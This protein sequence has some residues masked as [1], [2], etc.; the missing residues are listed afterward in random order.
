MILRL[1]LLLL[2]CL[3]LA[4]CGRSSEDT[5]RDFFE[6][7]GDNEIEKAAAMFSPELKAR[8]SQAELVRATG[9]LADHMR[10]HRGLKKITLRG[11]VITYQEL[12]LYD[13]ILSFG[14]GTNRKLQITVL[15]RGGEWRVNTAL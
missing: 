14:D 13:A 1:G 6:Q 2:L 3:P 5:V 10:I 12:A 8:F 7:I 4:A 11:G 9:Q 15:Y